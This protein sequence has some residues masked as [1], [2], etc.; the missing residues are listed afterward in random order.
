MDW[1]IDKTTFDL[2]M[3]KRPARLYCANQIS[4][5]HFMRI[6]EILKLSIHTS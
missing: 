6:T 5:M 1:S 4:R 3:Q 2:M